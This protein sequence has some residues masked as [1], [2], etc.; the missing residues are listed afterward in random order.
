M[1]YKIKRVENKL[2]SFHLCCNIP[3][4]FCRLSFVVSF[5]ENISSVKVL[6]KDI[7][8]ALFSSTKVGLN[9]IL[10]NVKIREVGCQ[11]DSSECDG[12]DGLRATDRMTKPG[13]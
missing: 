6:C 3:A 12:A 2:Y 5:T 10:T 8:K 11:R 4:V 13:I 9:D 7:A 1:C